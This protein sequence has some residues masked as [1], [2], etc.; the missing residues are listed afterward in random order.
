M[1]ESRVVF[2]SNCTADLNGGGRM[3][4]GLKYSAFL[5]LSIPCAPPP[6][7]P[8]LETKHKACLEELITA[9]LQGPDACSIKA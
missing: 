9:A 2:H 4:N 7:T 1:F 5:W 8:P 3:E 6:S